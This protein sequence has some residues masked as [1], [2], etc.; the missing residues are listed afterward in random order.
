MGE[1]DKSN[2]QKA[3]GED[4]PSGSMGATDVFNTLFSTPPV[5][6]AIAAKLISD[7]PRSYPNN[8]HPAEPVV[9]SIAFPSKHA[10][11]LDESARLMQLLRD[12]PAEASSPTQPPV[13]VPVV[14]TPAPPPSSTSGFTQLLRALES[15]PSGGGFDAAATASV[16][17]HAAVP[18]KKSEPEVNGFTALFGK[19]E[20]ANDQSSGP[21][22]KPSPNPSPT[23]S[24]GSNQPPSDSGFSSTDSRSE[25]TS[26]PSDSSSSGFT[27]LFRGTPDTY[28][29]PPSQSSTATPGRMP[30]RHERYDTPSP[31]AAPAGSITQLF[32]ALGPSKS[33]PVATPVAPAPKATPRPSASAVNG[34]AEASLTDLFRGFSRT[35][36]SA[37]RPAEQG[38]SRPLPGRDRMSSGLDGWPLGQEPVQAETLKMPPG[39]RPIEAPK[40]AGGLTEILRILDKPAGESNQSVGGQVVGSSNPPSYESSRQSYGQ[41]AV[42]PD[43]PEQHPYS[44]FP[45]SDQG[46]HPVVS[47][48]QSDVTKII[49]QSILREQAL[50]SGNASSVPSSPSIQGASKPNSAAPSFVPSPSPP[51]SPVGGAV[52][53]YQQMLHVPPPP[54]QPPAPPQIAAMAT[55][56]GSAMQQ[57]LPLVLILI[58][59]LLLVVIIAMFFTM[60]R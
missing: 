2:V 15:T 41:V 50:K 20:P 8:A 44:G 23:Y 48:E 42:P 60:K 22:F 59:F 26:A 39:V 45:S 33:E 38:T 40:Q 7:E 43:A 56:N 46:V 32:Q 29:K 55:K 21:P 12:L 37:G 6:D 47:E 11:P 1:L 57:Y 27:A 9:H 36:A 19:M 35:D 17:P 25:P 58:I 31:E 4:E 3:F 16:L 30:E 28:S 51:V 5:T 10:D 53:P 34:A 52:N 24:S 13:R 54:V 18:T 49:N 14:P